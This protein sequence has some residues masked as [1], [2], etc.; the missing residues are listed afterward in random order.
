MNYFFALTLFSSIC[1]S[2]F[3]GV[4]YPEVVDARYQLRNGW[5]N[6]NLE[7]FYE[8]K[9]SDFCEKIRICNEG[10]LKNIVNRKLQI[11]SGDHAHT[12]EVGVVCFVNEEFLITGG[13]DDCAVKVWKLNEESGEFEWSQNL[14]GHEEGVRAIYVLDDDTIITATDNQVA[15]MWRV[16]PETKIW[17]FLEDIEL[18]GG[19]SF[20]YDSAPKFIPIG[21][22]QF[23]VYSSGVSS[24]PEIWSYNKKLTKSNES[25][26]EYL[27][28]FPEKNDDNCD[29]L[30][31]SL[32]EVNDETIVASF[33]SG[34]IRIYSRSG[35]GWKISQ[36]ISRKNDDDH[37]DIVF[38]LIKLRENCFVSGSSDNSL[39]IWKKSSGSGVWTLDYTKTNRHTIDRVYRVSEESLILQDNQGRCIAFLWDDI[40]NKW[41][42]D[43]DLA[44]E[45]IAIGVNIFSENL[46]RIQYS[47]GKSDF[48]IRC[49]VTG[50]WIWTVNGNLP[51]NSTVIASDSLWG[52]FVV[53]LENG[54]IIVETPA[55]K[56]KKCIEPDLKLW[57]D[58][59]LVL[60]CMLQNL[61]KRG[62][63]EVP[64]HE[65]W[66]NTFN[67]LPVFLIEGFTVKVI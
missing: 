22:S 10:E 1:F 3:S 46:I 61:K 27:Q 52:K 25:H 39:K 6:I 57:S 65:Q 55:Y 32:I 24:N 26:L 17:K 9:G 5:K 50:R 53:G 8:E 54:K 29:G 15:K 63:T 7:T 30:V 20:E 12:E 18:F 37:K 16:D 64:V 4:P 48:F 67:D 51:E 11:L 35:A 40:L 62:I 28:D 49:S 34:P 14:K 19:H 41:I 59:E 66:V 58:K 56:E 60:Y 38:S 44:G 36:D 21:N 45:K 31:A 23:A 13:S 47:D 2:A 43:G 42:N 33:Y